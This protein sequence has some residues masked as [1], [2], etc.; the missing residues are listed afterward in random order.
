MSKWISNLIT[1]LLILLGTTL[2]TALLRGPIDEMANQSRLKAE[3]ELSPWID[4][5]GDDARK[6]ASTDETVDNFMSRYMQSS[7]NLGVARVNIQNDS[8]K[9]V[10]NISFQ[11]PEHRDAEA[12]MLDK[13]HEIVKLPK[14]DNIKIPDMQP[15]DKVAIIVWATFSTYQFKEKFLSY[16]SEGKFRTTFLWPENQGFDNGSTLSGI[17]DGFIWIGG[18]ISAVLLVCILGIGWS[19]HWEYI[20]LIFT[21]SKAYEAEKKRYWENPKKFSPDWTLM[22]E[23]YYRP[24]ALFGD[25]DNPDGSSDPLKAEDIPEE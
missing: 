23:K 6:G 4:R 17:I 9:A 13:E 18:S 25:P 12:I 5:S 19:S 2:I 24:H 8:S 20:K 11:L 16:S 7:G 14:S 3:V 21:Y 22:S 15:G 1:P 10:T